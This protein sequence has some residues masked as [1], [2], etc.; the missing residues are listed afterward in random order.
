MKMMLLTVVLGH[1]PKSLGR[2]LE[3]LKIRNEVTITL[4]TTLLEIE[5]QEK[6]LLI[7]LQCK[8]TFIIRVNNQ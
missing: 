1:V 7:N 6:L 5:Y 3:D 4:T 8:L 2:R